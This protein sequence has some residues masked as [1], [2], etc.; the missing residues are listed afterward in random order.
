MEMSKKGPFW[1]DCHD[2]YALELKITDTEIE[3][4]RE[5]VTTK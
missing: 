3:I 2:F 1:K 5:T 4:I